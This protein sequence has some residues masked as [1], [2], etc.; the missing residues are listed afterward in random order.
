MIIKLTDAYQPG[1][2]QNSVYVNTKKIQFFFRRSRDYDSAFPEGFTAV[3]CEVS[4]VN[5]SETPEEILQKIE[6]GTK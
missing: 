2:K 1:I 4:H 3:Y 6:E 5:V